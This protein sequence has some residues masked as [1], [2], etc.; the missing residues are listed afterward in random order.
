MLVISCLQFSQGFF[1]LWH[2][3]TFQW[4][5]S[6]HLTFFNPQERGI[7]CQALEKRDFEGFVRTKGKFSLSVSLRWILASRNF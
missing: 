7:Y 3:T 1:I 2:F 5:F 6:C 4:N